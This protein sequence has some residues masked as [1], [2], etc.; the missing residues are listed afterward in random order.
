MISYKFK[1]HSK[2]KNEGFLGD[3]ITK[4]LLLYNRLVDLGNRFY[5]RYKKILRSKTINK[6]LQMKK[7]DPSWDYILKGLNAWA[8]Q[9][10]VRQ[11]DEAFDRYFKYLREKKT[12][13]NVKPKESPPDKH[14]VHGEGSFKLAKGCGWKLVDGGVQ[15]G[16]LWNNFGVPKDVHTYRFFGIREIQ[17]TIKNAVFKRD[18]CG[19]YWCIVTTDHTAF[20]Q[21]APTGKIG[22]FDYSQE[23][24]FVSDDGR[25]WDIPAALEKSLDEIRRVSAKMRK[26]KEGSHNRERWRKRLA[27]LFRKVKNQRKEIHYALAWRMC[28]EYDV[29]CFERNDF[30]DMHLSKRVV[31][32]HRVSRKQRRR[33]QALAPASFIT[34][35]KEVVKKA[36]RTLFFANQ[37]FASSQICSNCG[38]VN[39]AVK[40]LRV[41]KWT[42][43]KCGTKHD[44]DINAAKNLVKEFERTA[45]GASSVATQEGTEPAKETYWNRI[46]K[47]ALV[48]R[49]AGAGEESTCPQSHQVQSTDKV[50]GTVEKCPELYTDADTVQCEKRGEENQGCGLQM[51]FNPPD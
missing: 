38:H 31:D 27:N 9:Q 10:T 1:L 26:A 24:F 32:G 41:R 37:H 28:K 18:R 45:G 11:R 30:A 16:R 12:N 42:C 48:K 22:G 17:G 36:G 29:L 33:L 25:T 35:L 43:L 50:D 15:V 49:A 14:R 3:K 46:R 4:H 13:P 5:K 34:I 40:K 20:R 21:L 2:A 7:H 51:V 39:K 8:V 23:H 44:R 47:S 19:D 6:Y